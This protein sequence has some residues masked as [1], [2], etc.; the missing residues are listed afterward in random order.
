MTPS[1]ATER[2]VETLCRDI[3]TTAELKELCRVRGF[4]VHGTSKEDLVNTACPRFLETRGV[5][6]AL[7]RLEPL[8]LSILHMVAAVREPLPVTAVAALVEP[9]A[10]R[11]D[12]VDY[13]LAWRALTQGL[14]SRGVVLAGECSDPK[15]AKMSRFARHTLVLPRPFVPLLPPFPLP[16][17]PL[18]ARTHQGHA[19]E[20]L[21]AAMK[22]RLTAVKTNPDAKPL[23]ERLA[24]HLELQDGKLRFSGMNKP[25]A[26]GLHSHVEGLWHAG[27]GVRVSGYVI[28]V[29]LGCLVHHILSH[30][31]A[32]HGCTPTALARA[33]KDLGVHEPPSENAVREFC[34][35]GVAA[36][37][38]LRSGQAHDALYA[39]AQPT[40]DREQVLTVT[41]HSHGVRVEVTQ[42]AFLPMLEACAISH[43]EM[44][45]GSLVLQP[46]P[47]N[48]G[49]L[50]T[51]MATGQVMQAL[52]A[53]SKAFDATARQIEERHGQVVVHRGVVPL[54][55]D[56]VGLR[57][58]LCQRFPE[59]VRSVGGEFLAVLE[60]HV[61]D[62]LAAAKKEGYVARRKT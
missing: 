62:V 14:L 39:A 20:V 26:A 37:L 41:A 34:E 4:S 18:G 5:A 15:L 52:R 56:D 31:P 8:L 12:S 3:L 38:L 44:A 17:Q 6:E 23:V 43:A 11:F 9:P 2:L 50:W 36:G 35:E 33:L 55:I 58:L 28:H 45:A 10:S 13:R 60:P 29:V 21:A 42:S 40:A 32:Q 30:L 24:N 59:A 1:P 51:T 46:D 16:A 22:T 54:R 47:V 53:A 57:A 61:D 49:R 27:L 48:M 7:S 19:E 25:T